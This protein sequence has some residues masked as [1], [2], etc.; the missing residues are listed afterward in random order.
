MQVR[1]KPLGVPCPMRGES[2]FSTV[3]KAAAIW[4]TIWNTCFLNTKSQIRSIQHLA[5]DFAAA[6]TVLCC[7]NPL[8]LRGFSRTCPMRGVRL[9]PLGLPCPFRGESCEYDWYISR[10]SAGWFN[11][12]SCYTWFTCPHLKVLWSIQVCKIHRVGCSPKTTITSQYWDL[13]SPWNEDR[14][15]LRTATTAP[16]SLRDQWYPA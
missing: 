4:A 15:L 7:V 5:H 12:C 2:H 3:L 13:Q 1:L 8:S 9:K 16:H 11:M 14:W 6:F 10:K